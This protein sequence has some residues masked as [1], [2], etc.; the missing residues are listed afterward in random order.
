MRRSLAPSLLAGLLAASSL[1]P[2]AARADTTLGAAGSAALA[3][4][5]RAAAQLYRVERPDVAITVA[6]GGSRPALAEAAAGNLDLA[7][8]DILATGFP[9][10]VDHRLCV[11]AFSLLANP[12]I[13]L[14]N[15]TTAQIKDVFS[16]KLTN[17]K[18]LGG[19]DV[20]IL[21][22]NRPRASGTRS[23]FVKT[24]L[25]GVQ[26]VESGFVEDSSDA[27]VRTVR[28]TPG[29][30][31]YAAF[32]ATKLLKN[33]ELSAVEGITELA[34]D[35]AAPSEENVAAG[36]YQFWTYEHGYTNGVPHKDLS[37]FLAFVQTNRTLV[38]Q[39][40]YIPIKDMIVERPDN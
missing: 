22:I 23:L 32:T 10:L 18:Q 16:G 19:A 1:A 31:S 21:V 36:R 28:T 9:G 6:E 15:L 17:W 24:Y 7:L 27:L 26:P 5:V 40:G 3:P 8:S 12:G 13:G 2:G 38:R 39:F 35:G 4:L 25:G 33:D 20:R 14:A 30:I 29:A 34:V 11:L 37:R